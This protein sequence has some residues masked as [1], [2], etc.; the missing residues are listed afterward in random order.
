MQQ[1]VDICVESGGRFVEVRPSM[2]TLSGE[3][4]LDQL[5]LPLTSG[6][7]QRH[8]REFVTQYEHYVA[9]C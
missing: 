7:T 4:T 5:Q 1:E 3:T 9:A 2:A 8:L 6:A